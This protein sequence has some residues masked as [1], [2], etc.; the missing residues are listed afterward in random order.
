MEHDKRSFD[1]IKGPPTYCK[2]RWTCSTTAV[3]G[4]W[5]TYLGR[6]NEPRRAQAEEKKKKKTRQVSL[7]LV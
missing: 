5:D 3:I 2:A 1:A 6:E 4:I 7:R